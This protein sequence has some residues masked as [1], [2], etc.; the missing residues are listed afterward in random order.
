MRRK[1]REGCGLSSGFEGWGA[2]SVCASWGMDAEL[3]AA[4][5]G[6][7]REDARLFGGTGTDGPARM[8]GVMDRSMDRSGRVAC[9]GRMCSKMRRAAKRSS[10]SIYRRT[11]GRVCTVRRN[12]MKNTKVAVQTL[13]DERK[14]TNES[15]AFPCRR[16]AIG[17]QWAKLGDSNLRSTACPPR[18]F[19]KRCLAVSAASIRG[20]A[21]RPLLEKPME[22]RYRTVHTDSG[23]VAAAQRRAGV[24]RKEKKQTSG[25]STPRRVPE[26]GDGGLD[27]ESLGAR[28]MQCMETPLGW[29]YDIEYRWQ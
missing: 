27:Q 15:V 18:R 9:I 17:E 7:R 8:D 1:R 24:W 2:G 28:N 14:S 26:P 16:H 25:S 19:G 11:E 3:Q 5:Q 21:K 10:Y 29:I 23:R 12:V 4:K 6:R 22:R 20:D 13:V